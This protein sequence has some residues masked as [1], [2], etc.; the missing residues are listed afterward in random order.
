MVT[1]PAKEGINVVNKLVYATPD[2]MSV[3]LMSG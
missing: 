1:M 2:S 3:P